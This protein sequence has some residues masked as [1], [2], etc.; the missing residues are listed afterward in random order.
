MTRSILPLALLLAACS[1][2]PSHQAS[3]AATA[4][5][6][7]QPADALEKAPLLIA[8]AGGAH[9]FDVEVA[10]TPAQQERGLMFRKTV[11]E[12][13][14]M[15]FPM[16]PPRTASFWMKNT[17]VP[18]DMLFVRTDGTIA[19]LKANAEPYSRIPVSA[20]IPVAGV[21]ELRGGRAADLG[22]KEGDRLLLC[23]RPGQKS[24]DGAL[25]CP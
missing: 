16:N 12:N 5:A 14:G 24:G 21:L 6:P 17:I 9:R 1:A 2:A 19:F 8:A 23:Q 11:D 20:G 22:I 13:G 15:Y 3:N 4:T 18:L 25:R 7:S 10:R